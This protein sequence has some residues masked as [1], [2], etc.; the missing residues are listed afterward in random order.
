MVYVSINGR[1]VAVI[2]NEKIRIA[3]FCS[4]SGT[5]FQSLYKKM[6]ENNFPAEIVLCVSDKAHCG[7]MIFAKEHSID[8]L[9]I[10]EHQCSSKEIFAEIL[11]EHLELKRIDIIVLAGYLKKI[12]SKVIA[13]YKNKILNIH[14]A[15]LPKFG[16]KGMYGTNVHR[17]VIAAEEKKSGATVHF[18]DEEYDTGKILLQQSITLSTN[19][20]AETLAKKILALEHDL[21]FEALKKV[22]T[23]YIRERKNEPQLLEA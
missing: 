18:V 13:H 5:N 20:T 14:P 16:G 11:L 7:A 17:A 21:Y 23:S 22:M 8:T 12:P 3:I 19:E 10:N 2:I 1:T 15:L 9:S 6:I 4:G